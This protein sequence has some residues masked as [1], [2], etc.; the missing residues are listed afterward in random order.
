MTALSTSAADSNHYDHRAPLSSRQASKD[1]HP[2]DALN[3]LTHFNY[4]VLV[5]TSQSSRMR[6]FV[7]KIGLSLFPVGLDK[8]SLHHAVRADSPGS[9]PSERCLTDSKNFSSFPTYK[10]TP[11]K[12]LNQ[13]FIINLG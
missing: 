7:H 11:M 2:F 13:F 4:F 12:R 6:I 1:I 3:H 8:Q 10:L 9:G 5:L